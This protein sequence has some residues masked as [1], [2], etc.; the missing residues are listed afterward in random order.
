MQE[1]GISVRKLE[2]DFE[3]SS[4]SVCKWDDS[5]PSFDRVIKVAEYLTVSIDELRDDS[6]GKA[7]AKE[8]V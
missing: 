4:G 7:V 3:F 8:V 1:K 2:T 5:S 6:I